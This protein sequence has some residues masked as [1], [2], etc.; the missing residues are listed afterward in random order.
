[1]NEVALLQLIGT[2]TL[3][4]TQYCS[5]AAFFADLRHVSFVSQ[6]PELLE[7]TVV[8]DEGPQQQIVIGGE[9]CGKTV[10]LCGAIQ[11]RPFGVLYWITQHLWTVYLRQVQDVG[12]MVQHQPR[13]A[14]VIPIDN[15]DAIA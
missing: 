12:C 7:N 8:A 9:H 15:V 10:S 13:A 14:F 4:K 1:M 6:I 3:Q 5:F 11:E 2:P